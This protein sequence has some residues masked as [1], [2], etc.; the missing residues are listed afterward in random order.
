VRVIGGSGLT[1][2]TRH[3]RR[4]LMAYWRARPMELA[5][6]PPASLMRS[7]SRKCR[8]LAT[9]S[10]AISIMM[11]ITTNSS[12]MVNRD[13]G[14]DVRQISSRAPSSSPER[15]SPASAGI[16][17]RGHQLHT[18][19]RAA[20]ATTILGTTRDCPEFA[21]APPPPAASIM[22]GAQRGRGSRRETAWAERMTDRQLLASFAAEASQEASRRSSGATP[23]ACTPSA[24]AP[25]QR[26]RRRGRHPGRLPG[27]G[28]KAG[29]LPRTRC[30]P[31][32]CTRGRTTALEQARKEARRRSHE[33]EAA[34][35]RDRMTK[36]E[37][38]AGRPSA[39]SWTRPWP[40]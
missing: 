17:G 29:S 3:C 30:W 40:G 34:D 26:P 1:S 8:K 21:V 31:A 36:Q 24:C 15:T 14:P 18:A 6:E 37:E 16:G 25:G 4:L 33:Q 22:P 19:A 2:S 20:D 38:P 7:V 23:P 32:G 11:K 10:V 28:R 39:R 9:A 35:M 13:G 27:P 5:S 12:S